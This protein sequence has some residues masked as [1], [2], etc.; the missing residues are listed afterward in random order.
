MGGE[1][2]ER[3]KKFFVAHAR[4]C[5]FE[6]LKRIGF[7]VF[8][9][10]LDDYVFLEDAPSNQKWLTKQAELGVSYLKKGNEYVRVTEEE[11]VPLG[12]GTTERIKL[13]SEIRVL[14]GYC[15]GMEGMIEGIEGDKLK[16]RLKGWKRDYVAEV[17][18][19]EVVLK[20]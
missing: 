20:E 15:E 7:V 14:V 16:V 10:V 1:V 6:R 19:T 2:G 4:G 12:L 3:S 17:S 11:L 5:D 9:P 8:Y 13:G 18:I